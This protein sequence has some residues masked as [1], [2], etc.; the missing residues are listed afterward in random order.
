MKSDIIDFIVGFVITDTRFNIL[1]YNDYFKTN[2]CKNYEDILNKKLTIYFNGVKDGEEHNFYPVKFIDNSSY[3]VVHN[4]MKLYEHNLYVF[5]FYDFTIG[6][7]LE[8]QIERLSSQQYLYNEML[9]K[10][11]DGIYITD[12]EGVTTYVNDAFLN[13]S[14]LTREQII[15]KSVYDLRKYN[16]LP[17]SCC[18][19]VIETMAPVSTINNYYKGQRCLVSGSPIFDEK[20]NLKKTIAVIRD[21]SELDVL[22]KNITKEKNLFINEYD[23]YNIRAKDIKEPINTN[24]KM[25]GIYS[26]ARKIANVDSTVLILGETGVGKDFIAMYIYNISSRSKGKFIKIN[27][28]AVPEHLLESEFFGYEEGAFTGAQKGGKKGLFEEANGGVL[29][30]DEIGDM[31]YTLQVKLL[32]AINDRMFYRIGGT[33]PVEFNARIIAATNVDLKH[34]VEEKKFRADLYYRLNVVSFVIPPLRQRKEDI[35]PLAQQFI[36]Y[37]NNK[38]GKNCYFTTGCLENFLVFEWPGNIRELKNIIE[39][40]VLMSDEASIDK[41]LFRDQLMLGD[42]PDENYKD[43]SDNKTLKDKLDEYEKVIIETTLT[44]SKNMKEA[45]SRLGIDLSTLVRKK[46]KYNM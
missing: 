39:R 30:L 32:S 43:S 9:N 7:E 14:G 35:I 21:V 38:Y 24:E 8:K 31:P 40:L 2:I 28:G 23:N 17:N 26:R 5:F 11:K 34:L 37:Y 1:Y 18:A 19:K 13:L 33:T 16:V 20:G 44:S 22:M 41:E 27:C 15:G 10:L 6:N 29:Y 46:Q 36:E 4:K 25:K 3:Y 12:E 45:A 42:S